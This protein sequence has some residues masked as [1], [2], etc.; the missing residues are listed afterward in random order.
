[1]VLPFTM[2]RGRYLDAR[3]AEDSARGDGSPQ[4]QDTGSALGVPVNFLSL[5]TIFYLVHRRILEIDP[6]L[7]GR[8][9]RPE[10]PGTCTK[11]VVHHVEGRLTVARDRF[12]IQIVPDVSFSRPSLFVFAVW[13]PAGRRI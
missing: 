9:Q 10:F 1:M 11:G 12:R 8:T 7:D 2:V 4:K 13:S 6:G 5:Y 3:H